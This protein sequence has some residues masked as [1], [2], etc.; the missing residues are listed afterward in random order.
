VNFQPG[1]PPSRKEREKGQGT[2]SCLRK[3]WA[4]RRKHEV[5]PLRFAPVRMTEL[6][7]ESVRPTPRKEGEKSYSV[8]HKCLSE[9][10]ASSAGAKARVLSG[11]ERH[12]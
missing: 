4:S 8:F 5:P 9:R 10:K 7:R 12:G 11:P 6:F 2:R 3:G 1:A